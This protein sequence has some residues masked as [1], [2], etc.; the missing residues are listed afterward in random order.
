MKKLLIILSAAFLASGST[1]FADDINFDQKHKDCLERIAKDADLAYE[2]ALIWKG[3]GGGRRAQHCVAMA[4]FALGH[5]D[6]AAHKLDTLAASRQGGTPPMRSNYYVEAADLWLKA[7]KP[8]KAYDSA[9][10]GLDIVKGDTDL[11]IVRA[12]AYAAMGRWDYAETDLSSALAFAPGE[13]KALRYRADARLRQDK[14]AL[15][16]ADIDQAL[17][18]DGDNI[19]TLLVRGKIIEAQRLAALK[20]K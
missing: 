19:D 8:H 6:Q 9:T 17:L 5:A 7:H 13:A 2:E 12:R 18:V 10:A 4:L 1:A 14:L 15:A 3:D 11:R 20:P 16:K